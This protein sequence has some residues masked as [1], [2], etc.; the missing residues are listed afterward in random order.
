[1]ALSAFKCSPLSYGYILNSLRVKAALE[2]DLLEE[3]DGAE[4]QRLLQ[5]G[6][7]KIC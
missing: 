1:M 5:I 4:M 7:L 2:K 6:K 3:A